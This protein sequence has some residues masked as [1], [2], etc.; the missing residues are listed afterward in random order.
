MMNGVLGQVNGR[1]C[2]FDTRDQI[3]DIRVK[4]EAIWQVISS[5]GQ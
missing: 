4:Q 5:I 2:I 1:H 3:Q